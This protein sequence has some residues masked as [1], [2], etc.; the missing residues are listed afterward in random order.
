[1]DCL[2]GLVGIAT[3]AQLVSEPTYRDSELG[4]YVW[5][6]LGPYMVN[7][8]RLDQPGDVELVINAYES[9][10]KQV[11][12]EL[13]GFLGTRLQSRF[14]GTT[15][16]IGETAT[17]GVVAVPGNLAGYALPTREMQHGSLTINRI[18]LMLNNSVTDLPI[19]VTRYAGPLPVAPTSSLSSFLSSSYLQNQ[20]PE[21]L[22]T[23][24]LDV[25]SQD[26]R[27]Y[28]VTPLSLPLDGSIYVF[29]YPLQ[30]GYM[31][32]NNRMSCGCG[33]KDR[34]WNEVLTTPVGALNGDH[35]HG[36]LLEVSASCDMTHAVCDW[37][38]NVQ[39]QAAIAY[40]LYYKTG[41][42]VLRD[43]LGG[44]L[45]PA[46]QISKED[47]LA[48]RQ[49]WEGEMSKYLTW[50]TANWDSSLVPDGRCYRC[51]QSGQIYRGTLRI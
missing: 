23:W 13:I 27:T 43:L 46:I 4:L 34:V 32:M 51:D 19:T 1:M 6:L 39:Y 35:A 50:L 47:L 28:A 36:L 15:G 33:G 18:G 16:R 24:E 26:T 11:P 3:D 37:L 25:A 14:V 42:N 17:S 30:A 41:L 5:S 22:K 21:V 48:K 8:G 9:A 10:L 31:P 40:L 7:D 44:S 2:R 12:R 29:S 49:E 45:S 20:W 38:G